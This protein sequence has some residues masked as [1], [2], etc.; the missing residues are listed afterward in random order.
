MSPETLREGKLIYVM[1]ASGVG[2]D[3]LLSYAREHLPGRSDVIF[4]HRYVTRPAALGHENYV[5]LSHAE[6]ILRLARGLFLFDWIAHGISY[7][8]G[9]EADLWRRAGLDVVISGSREHFAAAAHRHPAI[10]PVLIEAPVA[11]LRQ[12]LR[13]RGRESSAEIEERVARA[14]RFSASHPALLRV[15]NSGSLDLAGDQFLRILAS[16]AQP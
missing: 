13:A 5:S 6:F 4:C 12:R 15:D 10:A 1:G 14:G 2:K 16:R 7:G 3:S 11:V 8:I 9:V